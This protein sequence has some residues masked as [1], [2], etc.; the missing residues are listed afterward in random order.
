MKFSAIVFILLSLAGALPA[1]AQGT[2]QERSACMGDAF[3]FCSSDIPFVS[4]IESCLQSNVARLSKA[5]KREFL[6]TGQTKLKEE[7]FR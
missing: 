7:H 5:C 1:S 4:E 2:A 3:K 6:P